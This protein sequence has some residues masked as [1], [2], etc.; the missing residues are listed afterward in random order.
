MK[1]IQIRKLVNFLEKYI[2]P[3]SLPSVYTTR[4]PEATHSAPSVLYHFL[5]KVFDPIIQLLN[6]NDQ[7]FHID[8]S[9]CI[10]GLIYQPYNIALPYLFPM[11]S[12]FQV[13]H[14][15]RRDSEWSMGVFVVE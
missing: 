13:G 2:A 7:T 15:F 6:R 5:H 1:R 3:F 10:F 14:P 12:L 9:C 4:H 11:R 8:S